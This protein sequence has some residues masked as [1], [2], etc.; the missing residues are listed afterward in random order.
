MYQ[1]LLQVGTM[2]IFVPTHLLDV[3][4]LVEM[5]T[6]QRVV[7]IIDSYGGKTVSLSNPKPDM[8]PS[9]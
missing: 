9:Q 5:K 7:Q 2:L 4:T 6:C 1:R 8:V 3:C